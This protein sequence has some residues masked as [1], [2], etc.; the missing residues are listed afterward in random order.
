MSFSIGLVG[1]PNVGKSTLFHA[2]TK[3]QVPME[4]YPF[5]TIDPHV[6][7]VAV[8][9]PLLAELARVA[10]TDKI[11]QTT[12]EFTDIAGLVKGAHKGEGLG[13]Q[14]LSHV[15]EV[16]AICQVVR[17][18]ESSK[19]THVHDRVDPLE[20]IEIINLELIMADIETAQKRLDSLTKKIKGKASKGEVLTHELLTRALVFLKEEKLLHE[21]ELEDEERKLLK[22]TNL[23]TIKPMLYAFNVAEDMGGKPLPFEFDKPHTIVSA[24]L[25]SEL[26]G[27]PEEERNE[28]LNENGW[29]ESSLTNLIK[30]SY[31]LLNL[32]TYYT[33]GEQEARAWTI[34]K[35]TTAKNAAGVIHSDLADGFIKADIIRPDDFIKV[36]GWNKAREEGVIKTEGKDYIMKDEDIAFFHVNT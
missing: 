1:L 9:D 34:I 17:T 35:H 26:E 18:F 33:A 3:K 25:E 36:N 19:I 23:L 16:D 11:I 8:P 22:Q 27:L 5:C 4:N 7:T 2:I 20:D 6:G 24:S 28:F 13:N 15:R 12:I 14:F 32:I 10:K 21:M 29:K 30:K 31:E